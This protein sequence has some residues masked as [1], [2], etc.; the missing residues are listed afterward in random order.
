MLSNASRA[1]TVVSG[2]SIAEVGR[3]SARVAILFIGLAVPVS[4]LEKSSP[5]ASARKCEGK[6]G[7][8]SVQPVAATLGAMTRRERTAA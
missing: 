5:R 1:A 8:G 3:I 2:M 7:S 6:G 4:V